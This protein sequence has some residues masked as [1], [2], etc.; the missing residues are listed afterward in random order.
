MNDQTV[1]RGAVCINKK[2]IW[3]KKVTCL[4]HYL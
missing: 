1:F 3:Y 2:T 4:N